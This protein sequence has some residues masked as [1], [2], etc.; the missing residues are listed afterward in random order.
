MRQAPNP[1]K[2]RGPSRGALVGLAVAA[3]AG[4]WLFYVFLGELMLPPPT[5]RAGGLDISLYST[6][7]GRPRVG[8]NQFEVRLRDTQGRPVSQA[9]VEV[10]YDVG[11]AGPRSRMPTR[12]EGYG[13][14]ST[15]LSFPM[16]GNWNAE[17]VV[18][19]PGLPDV[20][21]PFSLRVD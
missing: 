17:V 14:F 19:R 12:P 11:G 13:L 8:A 1:L 15:M 4:V 9:A 6:L 21:V 2:R 10:I 16:P 18:R 20:Q 7:T 3:V 5:Q